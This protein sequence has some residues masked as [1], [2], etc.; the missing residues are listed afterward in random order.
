MATTSPFHS[1]KR[2]FADANQSMAVKLGQQQKIFSAIYSDNRTDEEDSSHNQYNNNNNHNNNHNTT[3]QSIGLN[4]PILSFH[5]NKPANTPV[6]FTPAKSST[7]LNLSS[8]SSISSISSSSSSMSL[9]TSAT[10]NFL[11]SVD[12]KNSKLLH[13]SFKQAG[14]DQVMRDADSVKKQLF[15]EGRGGNGNAKGPTPTRLLTKH[16]DADE[17]M[18]FG[19][20][21]NDIIQQH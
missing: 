12:S 14:N 18:G 3:E 5:S 10:S 19:A 21:V 4:S 8:I 11:A 9:P 7:P 13:S 16:F 17:I 2:L 1:R 20:E 6:L 15:A